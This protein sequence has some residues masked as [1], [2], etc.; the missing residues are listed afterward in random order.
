MKRDEDGRE[1]REGLSIFFV[2]CLT[3]TI[4]T[5]VRRLSCAVNYAMPGATR[6]EKARRSEAEKFSMGLWAARCAPWEH[7]TRDD[8]CESRSA[9]TV[10]VLIPDG[11]PAGPGAIL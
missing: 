7:E 5:D 6:C 8:R 2:T 11:T 3:W 9:E 1:A 4:A 10:A